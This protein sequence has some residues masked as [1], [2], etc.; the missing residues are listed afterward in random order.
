MSRTALNNI[1]VS[2]CNFLLSWMHSHKHTYSYYP[3][4]NSAPMAT[5][6]S[7]RSLKSSFSRLCMWLVKQSKS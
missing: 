1:W 4:D 2:I 3:K 6:K 5:L 7:C